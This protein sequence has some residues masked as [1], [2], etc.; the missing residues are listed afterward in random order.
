[1]RAAGF[2][3]V[4]SATIEEFGQPVRIR[5][6]MSADPVVQREVTAVVRTSTA[7][8]S[9][10]GRNQQPL[11]TR[12]FVDQLDCDG[13][14][15]ERCEFDVSILVPDPAGPARIAGERYRVDSWVTYFAAG[16]A[17]DGTGED[18]LYRIF[19]LHRKP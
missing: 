9:M 4:A 19:R 16:G 10:Y 12:V 14:V 7:A 8:V 2:E 15:V 13:I 5:L 11:G 17:E 1:M 18:G 3:G 6:D